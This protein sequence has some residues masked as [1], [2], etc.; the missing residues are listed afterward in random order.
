MK[1]IFLILV[2]CVLYTNSFSAQKDS[3]SILKKSILLSSQ[4]ILFSG[5]TYEMSQHFFTKVPISDFKISHDIKTWRG[6]DKISHGF[7]SYQMIEFFFEL[8]KWAGF[9]NNRALN[10]AALESILFSTTKEY[11]DGRIKVAGWSWNDILMNTTGNSLFYLQQ[12]FFDRQFIKFKFSY[13]N[14]H[15][16]YY[17]PSVL[18]S[19]W[20]NYWYKDYNGQTYWLTTSIGSL[21]LSKNKWLKPLG[22]SFGYGVN[23]LIYEYNNRNI[24]LERYSE[25]YLG[26]DIDLT[27]IETKNKI[28]KNTL[29]LINKIRLPL[30]KLELNSKG[31]LKFHAY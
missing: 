6:M 20:E 21:K 4:G 19:S 14:S 24:N 18:G 15:I 10:L 26:L 11:L 22:I 29:L 13:Q 5:F 12:K 9:N 25:Y 23:N 17:Y 16:Q 30:P 3:S 7:G 1:K 2:I 31:I 28:L 8:N 27:Q